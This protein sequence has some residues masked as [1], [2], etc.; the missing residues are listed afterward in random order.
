MIKLFSQ[1]AIPEQKVMNNRSEGKRG[2]AIIK[3]FQSVN[4]KVSQF[5]SLKNDCIKLF[6]YQK[7]LIRTFHTNFLTAQ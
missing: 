2:R 5:S 6:V 3:Y 4:H 7:A 1:L